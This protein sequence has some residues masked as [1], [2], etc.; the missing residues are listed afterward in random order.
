M[1]EFFYGLLSLV[2][3]AFGDKAVKEKRSTRINNKKE[4]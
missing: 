4:K 3:W 1:A 2:Q